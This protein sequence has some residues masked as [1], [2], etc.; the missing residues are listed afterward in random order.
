MIFETTNDKEGTASLTCLQM[1]QKIAKK[2]TSVIT[3]S[4]VHL[5][6]QC[7][8]SPHKSEVQSE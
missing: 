1:Q 2:Q 8:R 6:L 7:S 3:Y 4:H 5:G